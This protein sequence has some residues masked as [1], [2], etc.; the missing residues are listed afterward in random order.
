MKLELLLKAGYLPTFIRG[1]VVTQYAVSASSGVLHLTDSDGEQHVFGLHIDHAKAAP[2]LQFSLRIGVDEEIVNSLLLANAATIE[3]H[4]IVKE[5][6]RDSSATQPRPGLRNL[7]GTITQPTETSISQRMWDEH[8]A[9]QE[10]I[11][12]MQN[13]RKVS[14]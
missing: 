10:L 12:G 6:L 3:T 5:P 7:R 9:R 1:R 8:K 14:K 13:E 11:R 4:H 2:N